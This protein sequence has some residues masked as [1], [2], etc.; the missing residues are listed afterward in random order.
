[1]S[2][3]RLAILIH[4]ARESKLLPIRR[5]PRLRVVRPIREPSCPHHRLARIQKVNRCIVAV[6]LRIH[7]RLHIR[8]AA[9]IGR[10]LSI[11][12][13][14][15]VE[16]VFLSD[17]F[18]SAQSLRLLEKANNCRNHVLRTQCRALLVKPKSNPPP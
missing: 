2:R 4:R 3:L 6:A 16:D 14:G 10:K 13:P 17:I 18:A 5:P 7:R 9:P 1:L 12:D 15:E 8:G 11:A